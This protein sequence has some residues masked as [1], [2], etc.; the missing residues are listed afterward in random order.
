MIEVTSSDIHEPWAKKAWVAFFFPQQQ[1]NTPRQ[2][3][4]PNALATSPSERLGYKNPPADMHV[5]LLE[6]S[7]HP[8]IFF[9]PP[10]QGSSQVQHVVAE[11]LQVAPPRKRV[12]LH[13]GVNTCVPEIRSRK[14][15]VASRHSQPDRSTRTWPR[16]T[17]K[18]T[19]KRRL[20]PGSVGHKLSFGY[21]LSVGHKLSFGYKL[22]GTIAHIAAVCRHR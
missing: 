4:R 12:R 10:R 15:C 5:R 21:K 2:Q 7:N 18:T 14:R 3:T 8:C 6:L 20:D 9:Q 1:S 13:V 17:S 16:V 11:R 22:R 19:R